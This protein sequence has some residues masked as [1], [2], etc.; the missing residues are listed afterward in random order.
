[1]IGPATADN[2]TATLI[3]DLIG[4]GKFWKNSIAFPIFPVRFS[5]I[6]VIEVVMA[7]PT[8]INCALIPSIALWK[9]F[10]ELFIKVSIS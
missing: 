10:E 6:G 5:R 8:V 3:K 1:M 7:S 2:P 9:R 4:F